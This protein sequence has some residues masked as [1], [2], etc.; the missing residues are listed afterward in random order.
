MPPTTKIVAKHIKSKGKNLAKSLLFARLII[1]DKADEIKNKMPIPA[2][3]K[4]IRKNKEGTVST[5]FGFLKSSIP[6]AEYNPR[7]VII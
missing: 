7:P 3:R 4:F 2:E 1:R 6:T 5:G